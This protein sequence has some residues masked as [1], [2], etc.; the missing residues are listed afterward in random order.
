YAAVR[1]AVS[2]VARR[3]D[4]LARRSARR[5]HHGRPLQARPIPARRLLPLRGPVVGFWASRFACSGAAL[6][7]LFFVDPDVWRRTDE[8]LR[9]AAGAVGGTGR[10]RL[11][12]D[13][14]GCLKKLKQAELIELRK[15]KL[16]RAGDRFDAHVRVSLW[17]SHLLRQ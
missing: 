3:N 10:V 16:S 8:G 4:W 11:A 14:P 9:H 1:H 2:A 15:A 13:M 17:Q 5:V 6:G 12:V 7:L